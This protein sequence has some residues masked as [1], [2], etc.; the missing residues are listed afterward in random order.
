[1][2]WLKIFA[3]L[4]FILGEAVT[5]GSVRKAISA[6]H[7]L[8]NVTNAVRDYSQGNFSD[9]VVDTLGTAASVYVLTKD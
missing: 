8:Y 9:L 1:M 2:D 5:K 4:L 3:N 7:T 6:T